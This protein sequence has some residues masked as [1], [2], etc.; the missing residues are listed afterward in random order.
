MVSENLKEYSDED[1]QAAAQRVAN[2]Y[3]RIANRELNAKLSIP[4]K[5]LFD[6][7]DR[8]PTWGG[9]ANADFKIEVNMILFRD[10]IK[11]ILNTTIP[12]EIA[13]L[14]QHNMFDRRGAYT[15]S[16]GAEWQEIMKRFGKDPFK[17]HNMD[18]TKA[19]KHYSELKKVK[20]KA[21]RESKK[22]MI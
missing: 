19:K 7:C 3:A 8:N 20:R 4:V 9:A 16:H 12:H 14:V 11:D 5:I 1:L 17:C 18:V 22:E 21:D 10:N 13:H 2:T 6:L 15:Q